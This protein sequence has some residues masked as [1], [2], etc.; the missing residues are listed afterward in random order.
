MILL[1]NRKA[2][3]DYQVLETFMAGMSLSGQMVKLIRNKKVNLLGK[4]IVYQK[5][6][7]QIIGFG[8]QELTENIILLVTK[9]E[10]KKIKSQLLIKGVSC[11]PLNIKIVG[12]WL[13]TEISLV[14][15]KKKFDKRESIKKRD[16][17]RDIARETKTT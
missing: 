7:L 16:I 8:N 14:K 15:G 10:L 17:D 5:N 11:V 2:K 3:Y 1:E 9:K 4:Y 12:R 6:Q 13:K